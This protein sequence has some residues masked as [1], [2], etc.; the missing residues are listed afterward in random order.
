MGKGK[1]PTRTRSRGN[2]RSL[3]RG[4]LK[5]PLN[6]GISI[7][8]CLWKINNTSKEMKLKQM[9]NSPLTRDS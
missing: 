5:F 8:H 6:T 7:N 9:V 1:S 2:P 4:N 3:Y